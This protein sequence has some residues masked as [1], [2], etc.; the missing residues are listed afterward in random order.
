MGILK[1][2]SISKSVIQIA[3]ENVLFKNYLKFGEYFYEGKNL[4]KNLEKYQPGTLSNNLRNA[5]GISLYSNPPW[6]LNFKKFGLPPSYFSYASLTSTSNIFFKNRI[7]NIQIY[8][9]L[10]TFTYWGES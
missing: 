9:N 5:L 4:E 7:H 3:N 6:L 1:F 2:M 10:K 8:Y